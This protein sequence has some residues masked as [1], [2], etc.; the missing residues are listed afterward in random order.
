MCP[1]EKDCPFSYYNRTMNYVGAQNSDSLNH[2]L[3]H[4]GLHKMFI[5]TLSRRIERDG[6][7]FKVQSKKTQ[8]YNNETKY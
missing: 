6:F 7:P 5:H 8:D 2:I 1:H 3:E 4:T